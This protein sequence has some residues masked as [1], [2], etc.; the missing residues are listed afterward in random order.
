MQAH[1]EARSLRVKTLPDYWKLC[2]IF[3]AES[4]DARYVHLAHNADLSSELPM[5]I[6][7]LFFTLLATLRHYL[8]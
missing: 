3:G 8:G 7:G 1:P 4:S 2:V 5:Y 6:T